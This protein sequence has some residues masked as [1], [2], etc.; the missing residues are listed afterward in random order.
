M[1]V[2][3][4]AAARLE[5]H[6]VVEA[7]LLSERL[8]ERRHAADAFVIEVGDRVGAVEP[9]RGAGAEE[10]AVADEEEAGAGSS[11]REAERQD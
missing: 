7:R 5:R 1:K 10:K 2:Q 11:S 8:E 6:V 3:P 4:G 9:D